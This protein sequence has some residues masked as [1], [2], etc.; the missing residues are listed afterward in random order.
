M[1]KRATIFWSMILCFI[2]VCNTILAT[3][4]VTV[5]AEEETVTIYFVDTTNEKWI[6]NDSAAIVLIDNSHN[7]K[8]Y[9]MELTG[10]CTWSV[11]V[12][13]SAKNITFNRYDQS[14]KNQWNS[15]SAGGREE[16]NTYYVEG[17]EY[18]YWG[19]KEEAGFQAGDIIYLDV[20]EF[21]EWVDK[22]ETTLYINFSAATK[23]DNSGQDIIIASAD[24][25]LYNPYQP[26]TEVEE[27]VYK[28]TVTKENAGKQN[29]R[30]WRGNDTILWNCSC[31]MKYEDYTN[32][33][34]CIKVTGWNN[35]GKVKK[36]VKA[37]QP[38][39]DIGEIYF[40]KLN[41]GNIEINNDNGIVYEKNQIL[42]SALPGLEKTVMEDILAEIGGQIVGY[43]ELTNDYQ[44]EFNKSKSYDELMNLVSYFESFSFIESASLNTVLENESEAKTNDEYYEGDSW[45]EENPD[46]NNWGLEA[47]KIPSA[48]ELSN[49]DNEISVGVIDSEFD[50]NHPDVSFEMVFNNPAQINNIHG[51]QVAGIIAATRNNNYGIAGVLNNVKLYGYTI[52]YENGKMFDYITVMEYKYALALLIGNNVKVVNI[53]QNTGR[54]QGFA[55]SHGNENAKNYIKTNAD[56]LGE[57]LHKLELAGYDFFIAVA[58]GNVNK[59]CYCADKNDLYGYHDYDEKK[60]NLQD[61]IQGGALAYNNHF[62]NAIE[63]ESVKSR[64]ITVGSIG[65]T[66]LSQKKYVYSDFS[67][68]G[69]R[70]DVCAPGEKILSTIPNGKKSSI[71]VDGFDN[72]R[73]TSFATPYISG[74]AGLLYQKN[75]T[76]N[77]YA[78]KK[79]IC[80]NFSTKISGNNGETYKLPDAYKCMKAA[81]NYNSDDNI[82]SVPT[83]VL[84]GTIKNI[85]NNPVKDAKLTAY[86]VSTG[87]SNLENYFACAKTDKNGNYDF[88]LEQGTYN[89]NI[90]AEGYLP[91]TI[92]NIVITPDETKYLENII[93]VKWGYEDFFSK[94]SGGVKNALTGENISDVEVRYRTGWNN[95][96]GNYVHSFLGITVK[97]KTD[98]RGE[99]TSEL[100]VGIYTAELIKEGFVTGYFN[101]VSTT[102]DSGTI[103]S[104][105][106]TPILSSDEY[107]IVL[108]WGAEPSD[109]DAHLVYKKQNNTMFHVYYLEEKYTLSGDDIIAL[110]L[111]DTTSYGPET[112]T[113]K[114]SSELLSGG[115]FTYIV[116]DFSN[117]FS[118]SSNKLSLSNAYVRVY[119]GNTLIE[120]FSV[121]QNVTG[122][123]WR[124]FEL[125]EEGLHAI[126]QFEFISD[127][128]EIQ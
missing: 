64:I 47:L 40:Q 12:P 81:A 46:G 90:S 118:S 112:I 72:N 103:Q 52:G 123:T 98:Y 43:I 63:L 23:E 44:I 91:C 107:R 94:V 116:H 20:T 84:V 53:S 96:T 88:V 125:S 120:S 106:I 8:T 126:N 75:P 49:E 109:L 25:T 108:T 34:N 73:G 22:S 48:W 115:K 28:Y 60:D 102:G 113:I 111:D 105:V 86:R 101:V 92:K 41:S 58:A 93:A 1:K 79:I 66:Y 104:M 38:D 7:H 5:N 32:G 78:I 128:E 82:G 6:Q 39:M 119:Q 26:L 122:N 3:D 13:K 83:G 71:G 19:V 70:V 80:N 14:K 62:L 67:N 51:T 15:W 30:F 37:S 10:E 97:E 127:E 11:K 69:E 16:N 57:F 17:S 76:L 24:H 18:G 68:I 55:A 100:P 89:I 33:N 36:Y 110:D 9:D 42:V 31:L 95:Q 54:L 117:R 21:T 4:G 77:A 114:K 124:V 27:N 121:P 50:M 85:G 61:M 2:M 59:L 56:I 65:F 35:N 29:L 99:F 74:I 45:D 87:E